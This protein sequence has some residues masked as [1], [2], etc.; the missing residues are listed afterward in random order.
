MKAT[1]ATTKKYRSDSA[2]GTPVYH[3]GFK[4]TFYIYKGH[5]KPKL[6]ASFGLW[7]VLDHVAFFLF[8]N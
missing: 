8:N 2:S 4:I 1:I 3:F 7:D 6:Q 5:S